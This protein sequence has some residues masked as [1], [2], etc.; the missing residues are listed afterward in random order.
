MDKADACAWR[1]SE[2]RCLLSIWS[3]DSVQRKLGDSYRNRAVYE[4]IA[5]KMGENG[6][7]RTWQQCQRKIKHLKVLYRK[8]KNSKADTGDSTSFPFYDKLDQ[9]LSDRPP[10]CPLE[11]GVLDS[12][13]SELSFC[14]EKAEAS[15]SPITENTDGESDDSGGDGGIDL[16]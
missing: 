2:T 13:D 15:E 14:T 6:Y 16:T 3:E 7:S 8:V 9:V 4:S 11:G 1:S 10:F 12:A 5:E